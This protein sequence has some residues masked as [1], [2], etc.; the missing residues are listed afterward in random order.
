MANLSKA[1]Y[2][3]SPELLHERETFNLHDHLRG[4]KPQPSTVL[5]PEIH[6]TKEQLMDLCRVAGIDVVESIKGGRALNQDE[7][8]E[9]LKLE[10]AKLIKHNGSLLEGNARLLE[11]AQLAEAS[12]ASAISE[13]KSI[14]R[15]TQ[16]GD[17]ET[18]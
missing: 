5:P 18:I 14:Q 6:L 16:P 13:L 8:I 1:P 15:D 4:I 7:V 12:A 17:E 11:R 2:D 10:N 3:I 9:R